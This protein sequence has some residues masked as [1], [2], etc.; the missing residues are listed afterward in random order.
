MVS[1]LTPIWTPAG[2]T[3]QPPRRRYGPGADNETVNSTAVP[4]AGL[5]PRADRWI[6]RI[7]TGAV[8]VLAIAAAILSYA[9]LVRLA[10]QAQ[11]TH[12]LSWL[13]PV[14]VDGLTL[15]GGLQ[16]LHSVLAGVRSWYGWLLTLLGV[17]CSVSGNVAASPPELLSR[18]VHAAP[19][20]VLAL[21][22][23]AVLRIS[24]H[25]AVA[26]H[27][28]TQPPAPL[29]PPLAPQ[30]VATPLEPLVLPSTPA[31]PAAPSAPSH[32]S[33]TRIAAPAPEPAPATRDPERLPASSRDEQPSNPDQDEP[34]ADTGGETVEDRA[35][36]PSGTARTTRDLVL[37]HLAAEPDATAAEIAK[38][39]QRDPS[40][41]RRIVRE[42][43]RS[44]PAT[45]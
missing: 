3:G 42:T 6:R 5:S 25:R 22:L 30:P 41:V 12:R 10:E 40:S 13:L 26:G 31:V 35:A 8:I 20:I 36:A 15:V 19:P 39:I 11:I 45:A 21:S 24:R 28:L 9:G 44:E 4:A 29:P 33:T 2:P 18:C 16:V 38:A 1:K 37:A 27:H 34:A 14:V 17:A 32:D 23:E 7:S 43:R